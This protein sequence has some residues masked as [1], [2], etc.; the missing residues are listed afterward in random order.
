[1]RQR[2]ATGVRA[3]P[4]AICASVLGQHR[5][6]SNVFGECASGYC[7]FF[8]HFTTDSMRQRHV[9][10]GRSILVCNLRDRL[11]AASHFGNMFGLLY[12]QFARVLVQSCRF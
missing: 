6:M 8:E 7:C 11:A 9:P 2:H 10:C 3:L 12:K 4:F 1:M 5:I